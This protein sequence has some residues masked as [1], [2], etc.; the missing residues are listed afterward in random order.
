[1]FLFIFAASA[2]LAIDYSDSMGMTLPF[3]ILGIAVTARI[4]LDRGNSCSPSREFCA[5]HEAI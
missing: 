4:C 5:A 2:L 3:R 1:V